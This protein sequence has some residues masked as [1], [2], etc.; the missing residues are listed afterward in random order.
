[1]KK[2][3][4][5]PANGGGPPVERMSQ[6]EIDQRLVDIGY[7]LESHNA[8]LIRLAH[9]RAT[10]LFQKA[11]EAYT[12]TPTQVAILATLLRH[13]DMSQINL[14]RLT[15]IDTAT[16]SAM[17]RRLQDNGYIERVASQQDQRVNMVRLT[18]K[19]IDFTLEI[20]PVSQ[21]ISEQVLAPLKPRDRER[22][23]EMLKLLG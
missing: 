4:D 6:A 20:L 15:A 8:H 22:F 14:G 2:Q 5:D 23:L 13:G 12:I 18:P 9:Q 17:M 21:Q 3:Q 19:G 1:M 10:S 11:F 16:L 7:K